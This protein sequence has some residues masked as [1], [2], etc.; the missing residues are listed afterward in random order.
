MKDRKKNAGKPRQRRNLFGEALPEGIPL[1][2]SRAGNVLPELHG[3]LVTMN[4]W[5]QG[6]PDRNIP[7]FRRWAFPT[8]LRKMDLG[9]APA[10]LL[11]GSR[12]VG[13]TTL[14]RQIIQELLTERGVQPTRILRVQFDELPAL[15][16]RFESPVLGLTQWFQDKVMGKTFNEV[17]REGK[18]AFLFLDEVQNIANWAPQIKHFVDHN[19]VKVV[20]AGSSAL[21]IAAGQDSLAGRVATVELDVLH[22]PEVA[23]FRGDSTLRA[24]LSDNNTDR[25]MEADFWRELRELGLDQ[26]KSRDRAFS[27]FADRGGYPLAHL[28]PAMRW[29]EVAE[30]L[31]ENIIHRVIRHDLRIGDTAGRKRDEPLLEAVFRAACRYC[32]QS[33]GVST[34]MT[35]S[36]NQEMGGGVSHQRIQNYLGFLRDTMLVRLAEPMELR[37]KKRRGAAKICLADHALR[38]AWLRE[39]IGLA[40]KGVSVDA[41]LAGRLAESVAGAF[42]LALPGTDLNH[43]PERG[44]EPEVDFVLTVGDTRIPIEVKYRRQIHENR[45][46]AGLKSFLEKSAYRA[47]FGIL[48]TQDDDFQ[49][50]DSR[51][52]A[53]PLSSLLLL[54]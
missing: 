40:L 53:M 8:V 26:A 44:A 13:K 29:G 4:P 34:T 47:S 33:P 19:D 42:L 48:V 37:L 43:F 17:A 21:R 23:A 11:R 22:L 39:K 52:I 45:D 28:N 3:K 7:D 46:T 9:L 27:A 12:Q 25:L 1:D 41:D 16:R 49:P 38:A 31:R 15:S 6:K 18:P 10:V 35:E 54:R 2:V 32:G 50:L 51:I 30:Q 14:Q 36:I 20:V 24:M 5:W